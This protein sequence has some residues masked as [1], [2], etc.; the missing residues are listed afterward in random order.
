MKLN[1]YLICLTVVI[2]GISS[3][4]CCPKMD[5]LGKAEK[6]FIK[7]VDRTAAKLDLNEDQKVK[8]AQL[9]ADIRKN[10]EEGVV[11]RKESLSKIKEEGRRENSDVKK[12]TNLLQAALQDETRRINRAF[13]LMLEFQNNLTEAQKNKLNRMISV[14]AAE[15]K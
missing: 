3:F 8:L 10:F 11:E 7:M 12:M 6:V 13:D 9:K 4:G 15:L 2:I 1:R 5:V 14:W